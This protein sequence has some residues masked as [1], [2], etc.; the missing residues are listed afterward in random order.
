[1]SA[2]TFGSILLTCVLVCVT[3]MYI[4]KRM[5]KV[6]HTDPCDEKIARLRQE[7]KLEY[8]K[9][10]AELEQEYI[11][12]NEELS[13]TVEFLLSRLMQTTTAASPQLAKQ[14]VLLACGDNRRFCSTD[15]RVLRRAGITFTM[16][17]DADDVEI[18]RE[19]R[20]SF[21]DNNPYTAVQISGH[22][23][24]EFVEM[25]GRQITPEQ[26][27]VALVGV[28]LIILSSCKS[29][30]IADKLSTSKRTIITMLED[31]T[32]NDVEDYTYLFWRSVSG[33]ETYESAYQ[34]ANNAFPQMAPK[35]GMRKFR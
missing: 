21:Q 5:A 32:D 18:G 12:K 24:G 11:K 3:I 22:G 31:T 17:K 26:L 23:S 29:H 19:I 28:N 35:V 33:G 1:M 27:E 14:K 10:F 20:R 2:D 7:L 30:A 25:N 34:T 8:D 16:L 4:D 6:Q 13:K 9:K 15:E